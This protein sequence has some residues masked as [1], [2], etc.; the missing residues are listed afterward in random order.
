VKA[1][2]ADRNVGR[3]RSAA[4]LH[5]S[6][7]S[8]YRTVRSERQRRPGVT[9]VPLRLLPRRCPFCREQTIIGHGRRRKQAHDQQHD[10]IWIRRGRCA[11]CRKTFTVLPAWSAPFGHYSLRC[12]QQAWESACESGS[13]EQ[14]VP[15]VRDP[16]RLPDPST[17]GRWCWRL[18]FLAILLS[19]KLRQGVGWSTSRSPTILAW[20]WS[21]ISRI[22]PVEADSS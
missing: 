22:L 4:G 15:D 7:D 18:F 10:W 13:W 5:A 11:P 14:S 2:P 17:V 20:D 1:R 8:L 9:S 16:N 21:A 3:G 6:P 19:N 12:R